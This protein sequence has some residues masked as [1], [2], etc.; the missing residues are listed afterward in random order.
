MTDYS[1]HE[2]IVLRVRPRSELDNALRALL[3]GP[4]TED[5]ISK[6]GGKARTGRWVR[7]ILDKWFDNVRLEAV[8]GD[9]NKTVKLHYTNINPQVPVPV[10]QDTNPVK[11]Q[12]QP[13]MEMQMRWPQAPPM[14]EVMENFDKPVWYDRMRKMVKLGRHISIASPPG[15]GKDTAVQQLAAEMGMPLVT[16][17]GDAGFRRRDLIGSPQMTNGTS[18]FNV[19][20][21]VAAVV[22]GWW[23]LLTEVNAAD[24]D[25]LMY[26]NTQ[27]APPYIAG[28]EGK[29]YGVHPDF[30]LFITYNPG[31]V[32]TKPLPQAFK[33]RFYS[34]KLG[35]FTESQLRRR[36]EAM[37]MNSEH[38]VV[39]REVATGE[40]K[41]VP[42]TKLGATDGAEDGYNWWKWS[43][44]IVK[45]GMQL[46]EAHERGQVRYQV[47]VRRLFDAVALVQ[48][49]NVDYKEA[50]KDAVI[51]AIDS[52]VEAKVAEDI[53]KKLVL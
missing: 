49:Y 22:N 38:E 33:D 12:E 24:A 48:E 34:I 39:I 53:L 36:L 17:G 30:R 52:P 15:V 28:I 14:I 2:Q 19:A 16:I 40:M 18:Y 35:F 7:R 6:I 37:G 29:A 25:A 31:L 4:K 46:W 13:V 23:V 27:L 21:Y 45:F 20:E 3:E 43:E 10:G 9:P 50:L 47:T 11:Q 42:R 5:E 51:G 1:K 32:G 44:E 8:W 26:I 41:R